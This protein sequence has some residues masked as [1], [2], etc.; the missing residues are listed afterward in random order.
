MQA[1]HFILETEDN[2]EANQRP[3]KRSTRWWLSFWKKAR[4]NYEKS[5][6]NFCSDD[7]EAVR[8]AIAAAVAICY[9]YF[10]KNHLHIV[11]AAERYT[12]DVAVVIF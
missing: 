6:E 12:I 10:Q 2:S 5:E 4:Q 3:K 11:D 1:K 7:A 8:N 9:N